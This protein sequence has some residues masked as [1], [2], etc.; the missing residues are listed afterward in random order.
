MASHG[1]AAAVIYLWHHYSMD[2]LLSLDLR[3]RK[4]D[5][6]FQ[7]GFRTFHNYNEGN[8]DRRTRLHTYLLVTP[9]VQYDPSSQARPRF[10]K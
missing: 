5:S 6:I 7:L 1:E 8:D 3:G 2:K 9:Y 4:G 10:V